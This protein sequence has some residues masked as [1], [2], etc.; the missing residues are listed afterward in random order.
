MNTFSKIKRL[1]ISLVNLISLRRG[2]LNNACQ[3]RRNLGAER[4]R[5]P[6]TLDSGSHRRKTFSLKPPSIS[7]C[8][9]I[10]SDIPTVLHVVVCLWLMMSLGHSA[11][12][13]VN[14]F[15][16]F[17]I[18]ETS[19]IS[20]SGHLLPRLHS[21]SKNLQICLLFLIAEFKKL[22][23]KFS[24]SI[25][26]GELF[27]K[28]AFSFQYTCFFTRYLWRSQVIR[29]KSKKISKINLVKMQVHENENSPL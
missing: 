7:V 4:A 20:V 27:S 5:V 17:R 10:F 11:T 19:N 13:N 2:S 23:N 14:F 6:P 26:C 24:K 1:F 16:H 15:S 18:R 3:G 25:Q 9:Q 28:R 12:I 21:K 22:F 8:H 29:Y